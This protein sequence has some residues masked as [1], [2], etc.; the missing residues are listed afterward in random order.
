MEGF[1]CSDMVDLATLDCPEPLE[2]AFGWEK[3]VPRS[4]QGRRIAVVGK[5]P[6]H[7]SRGK[8]H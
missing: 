8:E 1:T 2:Q 4:S 7:P 5:L 6:T 3:L